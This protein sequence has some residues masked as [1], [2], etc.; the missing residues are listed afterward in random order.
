MKILFVKSTAFDPTQGGVQRTTYKM[1]SYFYSLG[2]EVYYFSLK[3]FGHKIQYPGKQYFSKQPG[4]DVSTENLT[5]LKDLLNTIQPD[6]IINQMPYL[7]RTSKVLSHYANSKEGVKLIACLRNTLFNFKDNLRNVVQR[8]LPSWLF[9]IIDNKVGLGLIHSFH[10]FKHR[11]QLRAI[12]GLHDYFVLL[13]PANKVE[14][15]F[16]VGN[17][18]AEKVK[19]IPNSIPEVYPSES[20]KENTLLYVG[21]LSK[22]H[23]RADL[24]LPLWEKLQDLMPGWKFDILG[25]GPLRKQMEVTIKEKNLRNVKLF[26]IQESEPFY[27]KAKIFVM[28]SEKEGFP[29]VVLEAQ[30]YGAI[31]FLFNSYLAVKDIINYGHNGF[32]YQPF[33]LDAM[34]EGIIDVVGNEALRKTLSEKC[35]QSSKQYTIENVG[36]KWGSLFNA[37]INE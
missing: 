17:Y 11:S 12:L 24:L 29:N 37:I 31:P 2:E 20:K 26:G 15:N 10:F 3:H 27:E 22:D 21:K 5:Q 6:I 9:P 23:K 30:S 33:D 34:A 19:I 25:D 4:L 35:L 8:S 18:L 36:K 32:Y 14:L 7:K 28:T 13:T 16:F 1:G